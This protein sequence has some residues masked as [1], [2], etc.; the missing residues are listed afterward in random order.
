M[1]NE[2]IHILG[3]FGYLKDGVVERLARDA[4]ILELGGG[5]T[6]M[7]ELTAGRWIVDHYET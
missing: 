7:Q 4:K 6:E 2:A 5:T 3:G 1:V